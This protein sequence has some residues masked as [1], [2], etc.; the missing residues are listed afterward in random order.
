MTIYLIKVDNLYYGKINNTYGRIINP[1]HFI[2][3]NILYLTVKE[4]GYKTKSAAI[5]AAKQL[6]KEKENSKI[7]I[8][9]LILEE[10]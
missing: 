5:K 2:D 4:I 6:Q 10:V 8:Q 3:T 1:S 9:G 7:S